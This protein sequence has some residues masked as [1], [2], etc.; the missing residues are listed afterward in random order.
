[1]SQNE[2]MFYAPKGVPSKVVA[3]GE[4]VFST[5]ALDHGHAY[6]MSQALL[7]A[8]ATIKYVFDPDSEK[9]S[10]FLNLL[11]REPLSQPQD[12]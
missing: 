11:P 1:M 12:W 7:D 8:G 2:G 5:V 9:V 4:F 6:A 10:A 3:P